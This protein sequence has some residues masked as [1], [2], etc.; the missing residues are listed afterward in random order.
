MKKRYSIHRYL[1]LFVLLWIL[2][3]SILTSI[4]VYVDA[5]HETDELFDAS[6][7]QSARILDSLLHLHPLDEEIP[8]FGT[9]SNQMN[10]HIRKKMDQGGHPYE[11]KVAFQIWSA[12][13]EL[14]FKSLSAPEKKVAPLATGFH[15]TQIDQQGWRT[16]ALY[17]EQNKW[18]LLVAE[19]DDI[20][21]ELATYIV[22]DH[23]L[24]L[25]IGIPL[26]LLVLHYLIQKG[27]LPL[28]KIAS[29]LGDKHYQ[30]LTPLNDQRTPEEVLGLVNSLNHLFISLQAAYERESR[31][32]AD[33][34]HEL[35]NPLASL[36]IHADNALEDTVYFQ[37][38]EENKQNQQ[39][40]RHCGQQTQDLEYLKSSIKRL[41][42]SVQQ[43]LA[44]SR[45]ENQVIED[46]YVLINLYE[47]CHEIKKQHQVLLQE[48]Q[49]YLSIDIKPSCAFSGYRTLLTMLI[50]NLINNA[51]KYCPANSQIRLQCIIKTVVDTTSEEKSA[52]YLTMI[53][54]DSGPGIAEN[55]IKRVRDRFYRTQGTESYGAGLGLSIVD[56]I[57]KKHHGTWELGRSE[58]GGLLVSIQLPH[59]VPEHQ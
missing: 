29:Q 18:W 23:V 37:Q 51:N 14:L 41:S 16:F 36:M 25:L 15:R 32:T 52:Q 48:K 40:Q 38:A 1:K 4:W 7:V 59:N 9:L 55:E 27:L 49:Q 54:E 33:A 8:E 39:I 12:S 2:V 46:D 28:R 22:R 50:N 44:L 10:Q 42:Y 20:R 43:L 56:V 13:N 21:E 24:P 30:D 11:K 19:S 53:C 57:V 3:V 34:A 35:R 17:S 26:L 6:L 47:L 58:L 5:K 31:F 45:A